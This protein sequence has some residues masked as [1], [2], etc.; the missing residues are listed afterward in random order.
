M[1]A[2][3]LE[4]ET[5][6]KKNVLKRRLRSKELIPSSSWGVYEYQNKQAPTP[7]ESI[8]SQPLPKHYFLN[9]EPASFNV[10][11]A[12]VSITHL[13]QP[14]G[15]VRVLSKIVPKSWFEQLGSKIQQS[16]TLKQNF[17][18]QSKAATQADLIILHY[19]EALQASPVGSKESRGVTSEIEANVKIHSNSV[20]RMWE[21]I[22]AARN[23]RLIETIKSSVTASTLKAHSVQAMALQS[24]DAE[25]FSAILDDL[26]GGIERP[27]CEATNAVLEIQCLPIPEPLKNETLLNLLD[28]IKKHRATNSQKI[29]VAVGA[30]V[31]KV[32]L[33]LPASDIGLAA[34]LMK[35]EGSLAIP[36]GVELEIAKMVVQRVIEDPSINASL[37]P[38]LADALLINAKLYSTPKM[39][40]RE[41]YNATA[42]NSVLACLLLKHSESQSLCTQIVQESPRWF[43]RLCSNRL[44]RIRG[45][46]ICRADSKSL[47]LVEYLNSLS[48][49][50]G[51]DT[52][53]R[54][55]CDA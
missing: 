40:N 29:L 19:M 28:F 12:E 33:N 7:D 9:T 16:L 50:A 6:I 26:K 35:S 32:L 3:L 44:N 1:N 42:L 49:L 14:A 8:H 17:L 45:E 55:G 52:E 46:I 10:A 25:Q 2:I 20:N 15:E 41:F 37:F 39:V 24:E 48:F 31:R 38:E 51:N 5:K 18:Q 22:V 13:Q 21:Q 30:A 53:S 34:E 43:S 23:Q 4:P 11:E 36:I 47:G 27:T 54:G